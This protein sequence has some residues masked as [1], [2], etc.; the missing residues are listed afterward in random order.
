MSLFKT[1]YSEHN[2]HT[3]YWCFESGAIVKILGLE[4]SN[5]KEQKYYPYDLIHWK[6]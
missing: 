5:F 2:I 6:E 1:H 4:D 3:G